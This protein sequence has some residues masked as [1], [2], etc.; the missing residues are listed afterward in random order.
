M[1]RKERYPI[2]FIL[3]KVTGSKKNKKY[4]DGDYTQFGSPALRM[5]KERWKK[6][7]YEG[8]SCFDCGVKGSYFSK[9][10]EEWDPDW[11]LTLY[12]ESGMI[13]TKDHVIPKKWGGNNNISNLQPL[14]KKCN[15]KK[16]G[17]LKTL[18]WEEREKLFGKAGKYLPNFKEVEKEKLNDGNAKL[19]NM[20]VRENDRNEQS[21]NLD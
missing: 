12:C 17:G 3:K 4:L 1:I 21:M 13:M 10:K 9:E 15:D 18:N 20:W 19:Y 11:H 8:V 5:F 14:C 16:A 6:S 2:D 7:L